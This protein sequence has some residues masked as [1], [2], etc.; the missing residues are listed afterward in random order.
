[1]S[2]VRYLKGD[3]NKET[4]SDIAEINKLHEDQHS[5]CSIC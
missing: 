3:W 4:S 1:M 5:I 2:R